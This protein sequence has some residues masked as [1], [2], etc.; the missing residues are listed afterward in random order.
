VVIEFGIKV[1]F[2]VLELVSIKLVDQLLGFCLW[3]VVEKAQA[4]YH[5]LPHSGVEGEPQGF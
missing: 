4:G 3:K 5:V 1:D 2:G